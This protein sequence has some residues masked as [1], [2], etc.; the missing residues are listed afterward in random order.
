MDALINKVK[1]ED[2]ARPVGEAVNRENHY[3][4]EEE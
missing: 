4:E 3:K 2:E 1:L